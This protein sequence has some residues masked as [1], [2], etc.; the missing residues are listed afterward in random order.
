[1]VIKVPLSWLQAYCDVPWSVDELVDRLVLSGLEV[2]GVEPQLV[3]HVDELL[4]VHP[5]TGAPVQG[6][7]R[8]AG[9]L[10]HDLLPV[11]G[12]L[13]VIVLAEHC[14]S[15][16]SGRTIFVAALIQDSHSGRCMVKALSTST[17]SR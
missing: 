14:P 8:V 9:Q 3:G 16:S 13:G 1:M 17:K 11:M 7:E 6:Y 15:T 4:G 10:D 2:D 12:V 5:E